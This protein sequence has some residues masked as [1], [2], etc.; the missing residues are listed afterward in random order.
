MRTI[1]HALANPE[2][3]ARVAERGAEDVAERF[4]GAEYD[5]LAAILQRAAAARPSRSHRL[6][7]LAVARLV[8]LLCWTLP[9]AFIR[10]YEPA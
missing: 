4:S 1:H 9:R 6:A 5:R 8:R 3:A 10:M 7:T 2:E